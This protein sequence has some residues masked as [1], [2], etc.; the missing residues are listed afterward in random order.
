MGYHAHCHEGQL[1]AVDG[2]ARRRKKTNLL[3]SRNRRFRQV[4]L[5]RPAPCAIIFM[6]SPQ[7][8]KLDTLVIRSHCPRKL[9]VQH[10]LA[11]S[12]AISMVLPTGLPATE[13]ATG[14]DFWWDLCGSS[15][16]GRGMI[17]HHQLIRA[18]RGHSHTVA[19]LCNSC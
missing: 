1:N 16:S 4:R 12:A 14:I 9:A 8:D 19:L 17:K 15:S 13:T 7:C 6:R 11:Q 18:I 5:S 10:C 2:L 3:R